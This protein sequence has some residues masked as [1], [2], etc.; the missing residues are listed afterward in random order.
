MSEKSNT[1]L[2]D[3]VLVSLDRSPLNFRT[4]FSLSQTKSEA[5]RLGELFN[6]GILTRTEVERTLA[7]LHDLG[8]VDTQ[9]RILVGKLIKLN[10]SK[11]R[12]LLKGG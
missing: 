11:I 12:A 9:R 7:N 2:L 5:N 1:P 10:S 8:N 6:S 3:G 4:D